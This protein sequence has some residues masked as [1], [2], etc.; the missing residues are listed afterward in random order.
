MMTSLRIINFAC[1]ATNLRQSLAQRQ[2]LERQP[3]FIGQIFQYGYQLFICSIFLPDRETPSVCFVADD[4]DK[5]WEEIGQYLLHDVRAYAG[6]NPGN[7][8]S[9]GF[10]DV[11]TIEELR[12]NPT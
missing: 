12:A 8:Y 4:V 1:P 2:F 11:Q 9:A 6:W 7:D 10:S 3:Q 5:A